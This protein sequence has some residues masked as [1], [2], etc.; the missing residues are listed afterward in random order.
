LQ[1][2]PFQAAPTIDPE[3]VAAVPENRRSPRYPRG[4]EEETKRGDEFF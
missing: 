4:E 2:L 3:E 1:L